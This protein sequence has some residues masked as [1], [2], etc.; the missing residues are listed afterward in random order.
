MNL[1]VWGKPAHSESSIPDS[2]RYG[3]ATSWRISTR[4]FRAAGPVVAFITVVGVGSTEVGITFEE[5]VIHEHVVAELYAV[6][7]R[8]DT[9]KL[10]NNE[11]P[12]EP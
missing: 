10:C 11:K 5:V 1:E 8:F 7:L 6:S 3:S 12:A 9:A 2:V 4:P